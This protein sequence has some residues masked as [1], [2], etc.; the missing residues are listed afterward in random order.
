[1]AVKRLLAKRKTGVSNPVPEACSLAIETKMPDALV[2]DLPRVVEMVSE[3]IE[4]G[5]LDAAN[6]SELVR[7]FSIVSEKCIAQ[8][9]LALSEAREAEAC[10][11]ASSAYELTLDKSLESAVERASAE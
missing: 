9:E 5:E 10:L 1:M 7:L 6:S 4:R 2:D 8:C 11:A 3:K